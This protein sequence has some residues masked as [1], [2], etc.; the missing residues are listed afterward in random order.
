MNIDGSNVLLTM[1]AL[2]SV[3]GIPSL[4]PVFLAVTADAPETRR[5]VAAYS[6]WPR[7]RW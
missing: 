6:P 3:M 4:P 5:K 2:F 1:V 7:I